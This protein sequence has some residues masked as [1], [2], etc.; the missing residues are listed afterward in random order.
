ML[1]YKRIKTEDDILEIV[2]K[3]SPAY[4]GFDLIHITNGRLWKLE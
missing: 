2:I 1:D 4:S 3:L